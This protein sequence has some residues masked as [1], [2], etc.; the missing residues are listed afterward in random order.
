MKIGPFVGHPISQAHS[1]PAHTAPQM[2]RPS[3]CHTRGGGTSMGIKE[4]EHEPRLLS[5][6]GGSNLH[7]SDY[8]GS[9]ANGS[10][11]SQWRRCSGFWPEGKQSTLTCPLAGTAVGWSLLSC[12]F[13]GL[14][15]TQGDWGGIG[16]CLALQRLE[17]PVTV[18][19]QN[20]RL[21]KSVGFAR[22][23]GIGGGGIG[24][25]LTLRRLKQP[26]NNPEP[27]AFRWLQ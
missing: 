13:R 10:K 27:K 1:L 24:R 19:I 14:R 18:T 25:C 5:S 3:E 12:Q 8:A 21:A 11:S 2:T 23:K 26:V 7:R 17:H 4:K 20:Q 15:P 22:R 16:R 9:S 6:M